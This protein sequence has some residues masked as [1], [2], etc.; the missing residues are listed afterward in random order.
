MYTCVNCILGV[1]LG[2]SFESFGPSRNLLYVIQIALTLRLI[3]WSTWYLFLINFDSSR[4]L[5][6]RKVKN[7]FCR[8]EFCSTVFTTCVAFPRSPLSYFWH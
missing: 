4:I 1:I 5:A 8:S 2:L 7:D 3:F 6:P